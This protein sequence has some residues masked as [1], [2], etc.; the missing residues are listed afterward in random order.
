M[1]R[2]LLTPEE[3]NGIRYIVLVSEGGH[4]YGAVVDVPTDVATRFLESKPSSRGV[5]WEL[6]KTLPANLA[7]KTFS[8]GWGGGRG[9]GGYGGGG[10][11]NRDYG[12]RSGGYGGGNRD[13]GGGGGGNWGNRSGGGSWGGSRD[14]GRSRGRKSF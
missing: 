2:N 7:P 1:F 13:Y 4:N 11:G 5:T 12:G 8:G 3:L 6:C 9:S 10:G 14:F